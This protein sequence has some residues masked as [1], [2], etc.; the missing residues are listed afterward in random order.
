V[1]FAVV[2]AAPQTGRQFLDNDPATTP[3]PIVQIKRLINQQNGDGSYT[4]GFE[5]EDGTFKIETRDN[6]GNVKG[7]YGYIDANNELKIVD[8]SAGNGTGFDAQADFLPKPQ[9]PV[10]LPAAP[11]PPRSAPQ[12][13]SIFL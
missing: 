1:S 12:V 9:Q 4:Y 10:P 8:Y 2:L 5:A 7:K 6:L 11:S 3:K 13:C